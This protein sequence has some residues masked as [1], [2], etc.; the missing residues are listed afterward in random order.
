M[1]SKI[2]LSKF[3]NSCYHPGKNIIVR[4]L[5]YMVNAFIFSSSFPFY[6]PKRF[7]LKLFGA[8]IG[9]GVVIKPYV[10]IKYPWKL[11]VGDYCWIGEDVRIDNLDDV[12]IG[13]HVCISQRAYL[14]CGNHN[15]KSKTFDLI[16][17]KII[18]EDGVWV[19]AGSIVLPGSHLKANAVLMAGCVF[20]GIAEEDG[21]YKGNPALKYKTRS[22]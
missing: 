13:S 10:Y 22:S 14:L 17:Q 4:G 21:I 2:D 7:L 20:S 16:I 18:I 3:D 5:W 6:A 12:K 1:K 8:K 9:K 19:G 15:Y 11:M